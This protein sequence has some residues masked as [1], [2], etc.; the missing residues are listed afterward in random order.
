[1]ETDSPYMNYKE[2][3]IPN[4][5]VINFIAEEISKLLNIPIEQIFSATFSNTQKVYGKRD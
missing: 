4:P 5:Y 1:M 3:Q 2:N